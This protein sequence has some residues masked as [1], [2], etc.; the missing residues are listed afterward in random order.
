MGQ[1]A[2]DI[3]V[4]LDRLFQ[5]ARYRNKTRRTQKAPARR[6]ITIV[7]R[8]VREHYA[9]KPKSNEAFYETDVHSL[10]QVWADTFQTQEM[11]PS[12]AAFK[13][14]ISEPPKQTLISNGRTT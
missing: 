1:P 11:Y 14:Q 5:S 9:T 12:T 10:R 13:A 6:K 8:K 2:K 4:T 7:A 3:P